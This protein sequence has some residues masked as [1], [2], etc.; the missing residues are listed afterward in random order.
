MLHYFFIYIDH[1][2]YYVI[3]LVGPK[4]S[5]CWFAFYQ[6]DDLFVVDRT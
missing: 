4:F 6:L 1:I 2:V 3:D 5:N